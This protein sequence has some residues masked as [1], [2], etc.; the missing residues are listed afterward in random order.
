M[1]L[2]FRSENPL[3]RTPHL[4]LGI[5]GVNVVIHFAFTMWMPELIREWGAIPANIW[6]LQWG[7]SEGW[8]R[9]FTLISYGFLHGGI[10]HLVGNMV[11]LYAFAPSIEN[12]LGPTRFLLFYLSSLVLSCLSYAAVVTF[13]PS[14]SVQSFLFS[15]P[16]SSIPLVGASGAVF[17]VMGAYFLKFPHTR[18]HTVFWVLIRAWVL[19]LPAYVILLYSIGLNLLLW[20]LYPQTNVAWTAH[21]AGFGIGILG[22]GL[23]ADFRIES[24]AQD[25]AQ[26]SWGEI[27]KTIG[28]MLRKEATLALLVIGLPLLM[29][30]MGFAWTYL[31]PSYALRWNPTFKRRMG[32]ALFNTLNQAP[33]FL[34]LSG[35]IL[36]VVWNFLRKR[37]LQSMMLLDHCL[38]CDSSNLKSLELDQYECLDCGF[39][40][41]NAEHPARAEAA[42][43][44][45]E[46]RFAEQY[47]LPVQQK[48][49]NEVAERSLM[50]F[51]G[52]EDQ[53]LF[54]NYQMGMDILQDFQ[55]KHQTF[56]EG[57]LSSELNSDI[58]G[59]QTS[60]L[61]EI[62]LALK[63]PI[64]IGDS[65]SAKHEIETMRQLLDVLHRALTALHH[66]Q[67]HLRAL[68]LQPIPSEEQTLEEG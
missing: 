65:Y 11:V 22:I 64:H 43:A 37:R 50:T 29:F 63:T 3:H 30:V 8:R 32:S 18:I 45:R 46:S 27:R 53:E 38:L 67:E 58:E 39:Q 15:V 17:A 48:L 51:D 4:T 59:E 33:L 13:F 20:Y 62:S 16:R 28:R 66:I 57:L 41:E 14:K 44:M 35:I 36:A 5:V 9:L 1:I 34:L 21:I 49:D 19:R 54:D 25:E 24:R 31:Y 47:L 56:L 12:R 61:E 42:E 55:Q 23:L 26:H 10:L 68:L 6:S 7:S 60:A 2:P 52:E 40:S